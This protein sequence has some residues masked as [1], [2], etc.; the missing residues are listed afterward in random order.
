MQKCIS[1]DETAETLAAVF[2]AEYRKTV[3]GKRRTQR[4]L[5]TAKPDDGKKPSSGFVISGIPEGEAELGYVTSAEG[6][7]DAQEVRKCLCGVGVQRGGAGF[8]ACLWG[9]VRRSV[10]MTSL[11]A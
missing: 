1:V 7:G 5:L 11:C 3:S 6:A 10:G 2:C 9:A 4:T 8:S